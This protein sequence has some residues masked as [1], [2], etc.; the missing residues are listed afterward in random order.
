MSDKQQKIVKFFEESKITRPV[1]R[2]VKREVQL[3]V[4][5]RGSGR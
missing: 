4:L 1:L 2:V 5:S 3:P